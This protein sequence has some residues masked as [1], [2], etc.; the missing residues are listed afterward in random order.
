[1]PRTS[2]KTKDRLDPIQLLTPQGEAVS[3]ARLPFDPADADL[4]ALYRDMVLARRLDSEAIALQR[5]G[6]LGLWPSLFGQEAAQ[7]GAARALLPSDMVFPTYREHGVAWC[8]GLDPASLLGL[9]RGT[10]LG[11]WDP[12]DVNFNLY[13]LVIGAQTL[14]AVG[15]AMGIVRDPVGPAV[16]AASTA[17]APAAPA[18]LAF[19]GDGALSEGETNEAFI[20]ATTQSLPVV[21]FCQNNQ[22][23]ISAP[24]SVQSTVPVA[25]RAAGFGLPGIR[26]DGNDVLA[27]LAATRSALHTA[28]TGGGPTLIEAFTYRRNAHTTADDASRYRE[29]AEEAEWAAKDPIARLHDHL[30]TT[31][32]AD[33]AYFAGI[34]AEAQT[35]AE[36]LRARCRALPEPDPDLPFEHTYAEMT[37]EL[38]RQLAEHRAHLAS[39]QELPDPSGE[40]A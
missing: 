3:D 9:F 34:E 30:V 1:M 21:F 6:E 36:G 23:A 2:A 31:G 37:P 8:R 4:P 20:W 27:C 18:V 28:R 17:D 16:S 13:T 22:W 25:Q 19:L 35:F 10:T 11:G 29:T 38:S 39:L 14:H 12:R 15:Y 32:A 5:Q 40:R 26:V 24:Y 7:I 33:S